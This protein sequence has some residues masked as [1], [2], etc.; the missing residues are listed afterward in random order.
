MTVK[1]QP[2]RRAPI[3]FPKPRPRRTLSEMLIHNPRVWPEQYAVTI[4]DGK[5]SKTSTMGPSGMRTAVA[6]GKRSGV[7]VRVERS[8]PP[9]IVN[10][11][12]YRDAKKEA[13]Q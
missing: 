5:G 7:S 3:P 9:P 12:T 11:T 10:L 6:L 13:T 8:E 2:P 1:R 4:S